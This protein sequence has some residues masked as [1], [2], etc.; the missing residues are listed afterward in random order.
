[1][2]LKPIVVGAEVDRQHDMYICVAIIIYNY[3]YNY[4]YY[5]YYYFIL[6]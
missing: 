5:Y 2:A 4:Y 1:M 6:I 3:N